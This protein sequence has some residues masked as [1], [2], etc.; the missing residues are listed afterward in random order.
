MVSDP[1]SQE[2]T[3]RNAEG[4]LILVLMEYGLG[5]SLVGDAERLGTVLILVLMEYG[6]GQSNTYCTPNQRRNCLNPCFNGIWSRTPN[7]LWQRRQITV[8][9]NPCFNG[10]WSRTLNVRD[11]K[12]AMPGCVLILVLME[13]GLGLPSTLYIWSKSMRSLNPCFNGI[14]SR[15]VY[16]RWAKGSKY[17]LNPCFKGIWSRTAWFMFPVRS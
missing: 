6:L 14:W 17:G 16:N 7:L 5:Q 3:H 15:T 12:A 11:A 9:L 10:I 13:Y 4:V 8:C 2:G 1:R